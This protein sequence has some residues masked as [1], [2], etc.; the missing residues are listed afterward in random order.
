MPRG[1]VLPASPRHHGLRGLR[2]LPHP[3][4][5]PGRCCGFWLHGPLNHW[6][7]RSL[8]QSSPSNT[9]QTQP[10]E[11]TNRRSPSADKGGPPS[12][13]RRVH[14]G[15]HG[16]SIALGLAHPSAVCV[17]L[18]GSLALHPQGG[19]QRPQDSW[20]GHPSPSLNPRCP[21]PMLSPPSVS[22]PGA[23]GSAEAVSS[24]RAPRPAGCPPQSRCPGR[25]P[26]P[27]SWHPSTLGTL[28]RISHRN[29]QT[30]SLCSPP[31]PSS[32]DEALRAEAVLSSPPTAPSGAGQATPVPRA[33]A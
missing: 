27:V 1:A 6:R 30:A 19:H 28:L 21:V 11:Q 24:P 22:V 14:G 29:H 12:T 3:R 10:P 7:R 4:P 2:G 23:P 20:R 16:G 13:S 18:P 17:P 8:L 33:G 31:T 26:C 9:K 32:Q 25:K 15:V 5:C